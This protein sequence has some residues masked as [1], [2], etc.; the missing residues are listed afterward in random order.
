MGGWGWVCGDGCVVMGA[1]RWVR[2]DGCKGMGVWGWVR[3]MDGCACVYG[4]HLLHSLTVSPPSRPP[5]LP[6]LSVRPPSAAVWQTPPPPPS[7]S[8]PASPP[9]RS[10]IPFPLP[11]PRSPSHPHQATIGGC[12]ADTSSPSLAVSRCSF[13]SCLAANPLIDPYAN[14]MR[15]AGIHANHTTSLSVSLSSFLNGS[16]A[17]GG[18]GI[19]ALR[20]ANLSVTTCDFRGNRAMVPNGGGGAALEGQDSNITVRHSQFLNNLSES[21]MMALGGAVYLIDCPSF[22][23]NCS[24]TGNEARPTTDSAIGQGGALLH[25]WGMIQDPVRIEVEDC[26]FE[27]NTALFAGGANFES[28]AVIRRT[29]F[30]RNSATFRLAGA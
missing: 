5:F 1:R 20:V 13:H 2:G 11:T 6:L 30:L 21:P 25:S 7:P 9:T 29:R 26:V 8:S 23:S 27:G 16:S 24:F 17:M 3:G 15:G 12:M 22:F 18:A 19:M 28:E 4:W 10:W 14:Y